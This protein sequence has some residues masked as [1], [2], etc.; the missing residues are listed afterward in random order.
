MAFHV[1]ISY[2]I[3]HWWV[4][5]G[6]YK[7]REIN[8]KRVRTI[9]LWCSV[10][11]FLESVID[12]HVIARLRNNGSLLKSN[13]CTSVRLDEDLAAV[14]IVVGF[15]RARCPMQLNV[16]LYHPEDLPSVMCRVY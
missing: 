6:K 13:V 2:N 3:V 1:T 12:V 9:K 8:R 4:P 14:R 10:V 11:C 7:K 16:K 5:C 15:V